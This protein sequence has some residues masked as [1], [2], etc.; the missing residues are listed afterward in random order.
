MS[1]PF[2]R[3][4][5]PVTGC[6]V[7][8]SISSSDTSLKHGK[9]KP[10]QSEGLP[11]LSRG[12][13]EASRVQAEVYVGTRDAVFLGKYY[14]V[15]TYFMMHFMMHSMMPCDALYDVPR[16]INAICLS[17]LGTIMHQHDNNKNVL[18]GKAYF[19]TCC[20]TFKVS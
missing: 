3:P 8:R 19:C 17:S 12:G 5:P 18:R 2:L 15:V 9:A 10:E 7:P 6:K 16:A 20:P 14:A 1:S 11:N 13:A 4:S